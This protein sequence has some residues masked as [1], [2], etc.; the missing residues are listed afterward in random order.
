MIRYKIIF[1][2]E[3]NMENNAILSLIYLQHS[4][5]ISQKVDKKFD[6]F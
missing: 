1:F 6:C 2:I 4:W 5:T 3:I